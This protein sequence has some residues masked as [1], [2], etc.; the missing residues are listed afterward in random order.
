LIKFEKDMFQ[1]R[2]KKSRRRQ[3]L[4]IPDKLNRRQKNDRRNGAFCAQPWWLQVDYASEYCEVDEDVNGIDPDTDS[5]P[6][7]KNQ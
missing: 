4:S 1:D 7:K 5:T 6:L 2:R 3:D